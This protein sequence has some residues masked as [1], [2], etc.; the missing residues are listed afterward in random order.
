MAGGELHSEGRKGRGGHVVIVIL[1]VEMYTLRRIILNKAM[2]KEYAFILSA[3]CSK[4]SFM[5]CRFWVGNVLVLAG[6]QQPQHK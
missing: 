4:L 1:I 3:F 6:L 5:E 2:D